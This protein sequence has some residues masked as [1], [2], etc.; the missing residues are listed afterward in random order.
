M[1]TICY[2]INSD[3]YFELHW[4]ERA[5][6][7]QQAGYEIHVISHFTGSEIK[8]RLTKKGFICHDSMIEEQ[9]TN[10]FSFIY[11]FLKV[12]SL[13]KKINADILHCITIKPCLIGGSFARLNRKPI[14][15]SFVGL[16]RVFAENSFHIAMIR[17]C[18]LRLYNFLL[19]NK[20][21][22]MVFEHEHDRQKLLE[23]TEANP[24]KAYVIEGAGVDPELYDYSLETDR[25][26]PVVLFASR[27]LWSKGLGDLVEVKKR[28]MKKG[29]HFELN[30]AG[31]TVP[32]DSDAIPLEQVEQWQREGVIN[33]LGK[34]SDVCKLIEA[35]N[36]VALPSVYSEG[37][38]RILLEAASVGRACI[39]Y[40]VGGC[41][42]LIIDDYSGSLVHKGDISLLEQKLEKLLLNPE[43]RAEMG[44]RGRKLV[45]DRFSSSL[46]ID[47]TLKLYKL[48]SGN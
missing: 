17:F 20:K 47:S 21:C 33:W 40:D 42:S 8:E 23:M 37:I 4:L 10:P 32:T 7:A 12:S 1:K 6:A 13:L 39:A 46:I 26:T 24:A 11:S 30:V 34:S 18:V 29:V 31:I 35:S 28:L 3:W 48:A 45:E 5:M 41:Q 14:I 38:P 43:T 15:L 2:F 27:L 9:S 19:K 22:M 25:T 36:I 44:I 16:G